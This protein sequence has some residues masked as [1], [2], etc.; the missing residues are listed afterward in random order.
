MQLEHI[1]AHHECNHTPNNENNQANQATGQPSTGKSD[2][3]QNS[4]Q[5]T[6]SSIL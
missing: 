2:H 3:F 1:E 5:W 4:N 6:K